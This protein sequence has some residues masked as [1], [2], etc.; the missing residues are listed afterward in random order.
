[1]RWGAVAAASLATAMLGVGAAARADE[2]RLL[3]SVVFQWDALAPTPTNVGARREV[4]RTPT[5]TLD[6][7]ESHITTLNPN[8]SPHAPHQHLND[9]LLVLKEGAVEAWVNGEW[10]PVRTGG[11]M[12]FASNV[13]HTVRNV[14]DSPATYYVF[15]WSAPGTLEKRTSAK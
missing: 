5:A 14:S 2:G 3:K 1:M 12:F 15:N 4:M 9:E 11:I 10:V 6:E 13:P 7:L 8:Q